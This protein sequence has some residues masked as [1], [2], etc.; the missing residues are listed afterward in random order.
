MHSYFTTLRT[1]SRRR[2]TRWSD[3]EIWF[4]E[5]V[6]SVLHEINDPTF[7]GVQSH[8]FELKM[9]FSPSVICRDNHEQCWGKLLLKVMH[10]NIA[11]L[12]LCKVMHYVILL[13]LFVTWTGLAYL[14]FYT[15]GK[16][17]GS[18]IPKVK[19]IILKLKEDPLHLTSISLNTGRGEV[20]VNKWANKVTC[21]TI[22]KKV[23]QIFCC[24]FN[25]NVL[26]Y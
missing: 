12:N 23:F 18:L 13:L 5:N 10:C 8:L 4:A 19:W 14:F 3:L 1:A 2:G 25:S 21:V 11:L 17:K 9:L 24:K 6:E 16:N 22:L 15:F 20:S 7:K 26:L